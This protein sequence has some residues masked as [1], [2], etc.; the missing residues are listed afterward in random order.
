MTA[1]R[2]AQTG[3]D[4]PVQGNNHN[5]S[6]SYQTA[7][8]QQLQAAGIQPIVINDRQNSARVRSA[9]PTGPLPSTQFNNYPSGSMGN[10]PNH[11]EFG[12]YNNTHG[13]PNTPVH[14]FPSPNVVPNNYNNRNAPNNLSTVNTNNNNN[15]TMNTNPSNA[16]LSSYHQQ[17]LPKR[18]P[19]VGSGAPGQVSF[20][21]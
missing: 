11:A 12:S 7:T 4:A 13:P 17:I 10:P 3:G 15:N 20:L 21:S 19:P 5:I 14:N 8:P 2:M 16:S 9:R 18:I 1:M 6:S